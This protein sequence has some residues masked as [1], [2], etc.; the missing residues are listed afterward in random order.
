MSEAFDTVFKKERAAIAERRTLHGEPAATEAT[1]KHNL[2]GICF[3]GGGIRSATF[4][5]GVLQG[6]AGRGLLGL[7]DYLSTVSGGGYIGSWFQ[8]LTARESWP[9]AQTSLS[10]EGFLKNETIHPGLAEDD[11]ITFLRK[12]S[13]YLAP[14]LGAFSPDTWVIFTIWLRN[15]V[16]NQVILWLTLSAVSLLPIVFGN[17]AIQLRAFSG[18][19]YEWLIVVGVPITVFLV[20]VVA[21]MSVNIKRLIKRE[22]P[23]YPADNAPDDDRTAWLTLV[24]PVFIAGLLLSFLIACGRFDPVHDWQRTGLVLAGALF[25]L[26]YFSLR[27]GG[28][29]QCYMQRHP[30]ASP[31]EAFWIGLIFVATCTVVTGGLLTGAGHILPPGGRGLAVWH[32]LTWGPPLCLTAF[33]T[34]VALQVGLMGVDFP[35][36]ARE[37]YA[38]LAARLLILS[39]GWIVLF[40][41]VV[42]SPMLVLWFFHNYTKVSIGTTLAWMLTT[43]AGFQAGKN[44]GTAGAPAG[45]AAPPK[46]RNVTLERV[47]RFAP[48]LA[49]LG[50]LI[51]VSTGCFVAI[52]KMW[53]MRGSHPVMQA[54]PLPQAA[55][56]VNASGSGTLQVNW[57]SDNS[58]DWWTSFKRYPHDYRALWLETSLNWWVFGSSALL[59]LLGVL[60]SLRVNINEFSMNHFYKNRLVRCYLGASHG[61]HRRPNRFTGFDPHDDIPLTELVPGKNHDAPYSIINCTLNLNQGKELAWQ[62]RKA[63]SFVFTPLFC[64]YNPARKASVGRGYVPT[65]E[66]T[67]SGGPHLGLATAISGAAANPNW[68]YHTSPVT[69]FLMT[70]FNV[71]LGWW[72]GNTRTDRLAKTAGPAFALKYLF[73]EL[74][75]QTDEE[76]SYLNLSDGGHFENLGLYE[77]IRRRCRFIIVGDGEEDENYV[78]ES[79]GG[80]IRKARIDFGVD[81]TISP[82]RIF[83]ADAASSVHCATGTIDYHD[84]ITGQI[85]YIKSSV[86]GDESWDIS[87]YKKG[88]EAFPQQS[89]LNQFFTESQFESYR[90][91]GKH[92]VD[93][94]FE[95]T[96]LPGTHAEL[97][98]LFDELRSNW[99]PPASAPPGA[100][101][102]H[103]AAYAALVQRLGADN[104]LRF[105]DSQLVPGFPPQSLAAISPAAVRKG[106]LLLLDFIQLMEDVYIDLNLEDDAERRHPQNQ[107]WI[108]LFKLWSR[109][110]SAMDA[111]WQKVGPSYGTAFQR[112]YRELHQ[113]NP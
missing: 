68:G 8:G 91:L 34:G 54:A 110:G 94:I 90:A 62:E 76:C 107:G 89:T 55:M 17:L 64:G 96:S 13:N 48:P 18:R 16:L 14:Q 78:F 36:S 37:W 51:A 33:A 101:T 86:T 105:L 30:G 27:D 74:F 41:I 19:F 49:V 73:A 24:L 47:A 80:A 63:S 59:A 82:K 11:P 71:R 28:F 84:G 104:E 21:R 29:P 77:L 69:A 60:M 102:K 87:Q 42:F 58:P 65:H 98:T 31:T 70:I 3:S 43:F 61:A 35:D 9:G 6:L 39:V 23:P 7:A 52:E 99:L 50:L 53:P 79:L 10:A 111:V 97:P 95:K 108:G 44:P 4:N 109:P 106:T 20:L 75:G 57:N 12:Y 2:F 22:F 93:R 32:C 66:F 100:F 40:G 103:A 5:L 88:H 67:G 72:V 81:I 113:E 56:S 25:V 83:P 85:L 46:A 92:I 26:F 38:R 112:F 1:V 15:T 45:N